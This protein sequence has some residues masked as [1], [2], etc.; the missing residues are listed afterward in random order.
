[1]RFGS[2]RRLEQLVA[3]SMYLISAVLVLGTT[4]LPAW[5]NAAP[6]PRFLPLAVAAVVVILA[7][8]LLIEAR[9]RD[10]DAPAEWPDRPG[11]MRVGLTILGVIAYIAMA[12]WTGF[13]FGSALFTLFILLVVT[14]QKLLPSLLVT[15]IVTGLVQVIFISWLDIALPRGVFGG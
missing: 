9:R 7:S 4:E 5:E 1:M 6:G 15:A 2:M 13:V 3:V 8:L 10:P 11:I 14:R 12:P